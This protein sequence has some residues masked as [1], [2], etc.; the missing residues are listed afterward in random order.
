MSA[1]LGTPSRVAAVWTLTAQYVCTQR[2]ENFEID[3][4]ALRSLSQL[5]LAGMRE[6][7]SANERMQLI[8][9][10]LTISATQQVNQ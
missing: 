8:N 10:V 4:Q 6:G 7:L 9:S 3:V 1:F 5:H 2:Y